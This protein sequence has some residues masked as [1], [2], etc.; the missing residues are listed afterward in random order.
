[1]AISKIGTNSIDTLTSISFAASQTASS[2]AN[3]LDDYEEGTYTIAMTAGSSGTITMDGSYNTGHYTKIGDTVMVCGNPR[4]SSVSSPNGTTFISLPFTS[5][6]NGLAQTSSSVLEAGVTYQTNQK[7]GFLIR[8]LANTATAEVIYNT[9]GDYF[10]LQAQNA[11]FGS[12]DQFSF[13]VT[14][15]V[16]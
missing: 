1:M 14:Y 2:D 3:T 9:D 13:S 5:K 7:G 11:G 10:T 4:I 6:N 8:T 16:E 12:S 15:K